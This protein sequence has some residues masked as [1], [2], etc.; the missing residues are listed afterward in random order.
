VAEFS[1]SAK[2]E[3][4]VR[5]DRKVRLEV[6]G[7]NYITLLS[8]QPFVTSPS[9][10][11][12]ST[13]IASSRYPQKKKYTIATVATEDFREFDEITLT[14]VVDAD[15]PSDSIFVVETPAVVAQIFRCINIQ[16][17]PARLVR[18]FRP[19]I[20]SWEIRCE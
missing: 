12:D 2:T 9:Q 8:P 3:K 17:K 19:R 13:E 7:T 11:E 14:E 16:G 20:Q 4:T 18:S 6:V 15:T 1:L 5:L 10:I